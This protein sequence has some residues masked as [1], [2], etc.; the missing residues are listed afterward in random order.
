MFRRKQLACSFCGRDN[1]EVNKLVA[2]PRVFIYDRCALEVIRIMDESGNVSN[3][4][5]QRT[6]LLRQVFQRVFSTRKRNSPHSPEFH[7]VSV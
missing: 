2:G 3:R 4:P 5:E 7:A 6:G 1:A